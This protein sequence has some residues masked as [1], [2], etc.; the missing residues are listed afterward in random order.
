MMKKS[1]IPA[2]LGISMLLTACQPATNQGTTS[3]A[4]GT[5]GQTS[6]AAGTQS[7]ITSPVTSAGT[8]PMPTT[9]SPA[10][11]RPNADDLTFASYD[12]L[13]TFTID[14]ALALWEREFP[15]A[16]ITS[17][18][19]DFSDISWYYHMDGI[20]DS[21]E[22]SLRVDA[23]SGEI[24]GRESE[25]D[26]DDDKPIDYTAIIS[27]KEALEAAKAETAADTIIEEWKLDWDWF[28]TDSIWYEFEL[29]NPDEEI[30]V[31]ARD[32]SIK[33]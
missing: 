29:D 3:P 18:E 8:Q 5:S 33:R 12:E 24:R 20:Q 11:T 30:G 28:G 26:D 2:F 27:L 14:D 4:A 22:H 15:G 13:I 7:I 16:K 31:N 10:A 23:V 25:N 32:R 9:T 6:V 21:K 1:L 19:F 17:I